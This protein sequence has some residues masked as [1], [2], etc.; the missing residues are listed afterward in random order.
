MV[1]LISP[2][3]SK[4]AKAFSE[5]IGRES[6]TLNDYNPVRLNPV[7][8]LLP[9]LDKVSFSVTRSRASCYHPIRSG[10]PAPYDTSE[11]R[12]LHTQCN[13][14]DDIYCHC[15]RICGMKSANSHVAEF[16]DNL[17][18]I[19]SRNGGT[20]TFK[21]YREEEDCFKVVVKLTETSLSGKPVCFYSTNRLWKGSRHSEVV[22][23][24]NRYGEAQM[25]MFDPKPMTFT[26]YN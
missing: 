19:R 18:R 6:L 20:A 11:I 7:K 21:C 15:P 13:Q 17:N 10:L 3:I 16:V 8:G 5:S 23:F 14:W 4:T 25:L 12:Q 22:G 9:R 1:M 26:D 24:S 2:V